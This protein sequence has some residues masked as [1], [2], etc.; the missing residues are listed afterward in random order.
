L[1]AHGVTTVRG[2]HDRWFDAGTMRSLPDATREDELD[3]VGRAFLAGLPVEREFATPSG[4]LLLCH[5]LGKN[6]MARLGPDDF[7]YALE[8]NDELQSLLGLAR[9]RWIVNGHTHRRMVRKFASLTVINA[10]TLKRDN[11]PCI[12][13]IDFAGARGGFLRLLGRRAFD[14]T[15]RK[16]HALSMLASLSE[17]QVLPVAALLA[18]AFV[19]NA[20]YSF[21]FPDVARRRELLADFFARNL[22]THLPHRCTYVWTPEPER[23]LATVTV[24]P[25]G[26]IPISLATM[27]RRGLLPFAV[28]NG[29]NAVRRLF[30]LIEHTD[31][32]DTEATGGRSHF[33]LHMMAV[34][35]E[36]QGAG[37]GTALLRAAMGAKISQP[38]AQ[39]P[40]SLSTE[41][42]E[43]LSFYRRLGFETKGEYE[44]GGVAGGPLFRT[45]TML[46]EG[47]A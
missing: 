47:S 23:V 12:A 18:D 19:D 38:E 13:V 28:K 26:G 5:G 3:S 40:I 35:P 29:V 9:H 31:R 22:Q 42:P 33:H 10:G 16:L 39:R 46:R 27:I 34:H 8:S 36:H 25:P 30:Y 11:H 44:L 17:H 4:S 20:A 6:D 2:N 37:I 32:I 15:G 7:G 21:L 41:R 14:G 1:R 45:W 24:R 43:N